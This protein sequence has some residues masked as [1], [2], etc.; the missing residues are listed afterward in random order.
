MNKNILIIYYTQS[1]QLAEIVKSF[2]GP[3]IKAG[4]TVEEVCV[5][6]VGDY[7]FPWTSASFFNT[8]PESVLGIPI[9]LQPLNFKATVYDLIIFA[10]QPWFL[11]PSIPA[12][13]ILKH[14][15]FKAL[16]QNTPVVTLIGARNM[17]LNAQQKVVLLLKEAG[18][19]LVGNIALTDKNNNYSSAVSILYWMLTGKKERYKGIFPKPGVSDEDIQNAHV[20]GRIVL[21]H[22]EKNDL[23]GLPEGLI[24]AGALPIIADL[25]FIEARAGKLFSLWA[26]LIRK[27]EN[28]APWIVLFKYYL[29]VALFII[30][31]M[32]L[33]I[34]MISFKP[35]LSKSIARKKRYHLGLN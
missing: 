17:W 27:K 29:L 33:F 34:N 9:P 26:N 12:T 3:F 6:P 15:Q 23:N 4:V 14:P 32:V 35:F 1:G 8:M 30:A 18:A 16:L 2:A 25:M 5:K 7:P 22:F 24:D 11:S 10:Y 20:F 13:S 19:K 31:P 28:R 21:N